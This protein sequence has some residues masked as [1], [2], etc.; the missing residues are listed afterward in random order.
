M[1][2][3]SY[4]SGKVYIRVKHFIYFH[5]NV[6]R[7]DIKDEMLHF[8]V[9]LFWPNVWDLATLNMPTNQ[10]HFVSF[11]TFFSFDSVFYVTGPKLLYAL[12]FYIPYMIARE[13]W[14]QGALLLNWVFSNSFRDHLVLKVVI[15]SQTFECFWISVTRIRSNHVNRNWYSAGQQIISIE[16]YLLLPFNSTEML[17][18][19]Y[20]QITFKQT[21]WF[22]QP[23]KATAAPKNHFIQNRSLHVSLYVGHAVQKIFDGVKLFLEKC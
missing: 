5:Y 18:L 10:R 3:P 7:R 15:T 11:F 23:S 4:R 8:G 13:R 21:A 20:K 12:W 16:D 6:A 2:E 14:F 19:H 1:V 9:A 22:S 17:K